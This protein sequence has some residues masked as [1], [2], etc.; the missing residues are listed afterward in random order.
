MI[1]T[2]I[3]GN[4][5]VLIAS[6][7]KI[8]AEAGMRIADVTYGKGNFWK[9]VNTKLYEFY[10]SDIK[11]GVDFRATDYR[12]N[13]M[14]I[15]VF[16][17]PYM[18]TTAGN[19]KDNME[20]SYGVT[21]DLPDNYAVLDL[22][23]GGMAEAYRILHPGGTLWVKCQDTQKSNKHYW[24]HIEIY[25]YACHMGFESLDFFVLC[26][27]GVMPS[28]YKYQLT[29]RKNHSYLWIFKKPGTPRVIKQIDRG[30]SLPYEQLSLV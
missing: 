18:Y 4:N 21:P 27:R 1:V 28:K 3:K 11:T 12:H 20:D 5:D 6:A 22:Y 16:D 17:P 24:N 2:C 26:P 29:A 10:P 14:D 15:V 23:W 19:M 13:F 9:L 25:N 8:H 30:D 7:A